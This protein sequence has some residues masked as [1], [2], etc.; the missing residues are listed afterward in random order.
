MLVVWQSALSRIHDWKAGMDEEQCQEEGALPVS[1][2]VDAVMQQVA[3]IARRPLKVHLEVHAIEA[4]IGVDE[5]IEHLHLGFSNYTKKTAAAKPKKVPSKGAAGAKAALDASKKKPLDVQ[6]REMEWWQQ[7]AKNALKLLKQNLNQLSVNISGLFQGRRQGCDPT[8]LVAA[9]EVGYQGPVNIQ[10]ALTSMSMGAWPF[11]TQITSMPDG[12]LEVKILLPTRTDTEGGALA[13]V[14]IEQLSVTISLDLERVQRLTQLQSQRVFELEL[15]PN[16]SA[17]PQVPSVEDANGIAPQKATEPTSKKEPGMGSDLHERLTLYYEQH[18]RDMLVQID[19]VLQL[20][21][22]REEELW[23]DMDHKYGTI[24]AQGGWSMLPADHVQM[25]A[26]SSL[27]KVSV[28]S[29]G[30]ADAPGGSSNAAAVAS[31]SDTDSSHS[32]KLSSGDFTTFSVTSSKIR[33]EVNYATCSNNS[34]EL[35][36]FLLLKMDPHRAFDFNSF[37]QLVAR[38]SMYLE[39][40]S[41]LFRFSLSVACLVEA[42]ELRFYANSLQQ[43]HE[44]AVTFHHVVSLWDFVDDLVELKTVLGQQIDTTKEMPE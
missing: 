14:S 11:P 16:L 25:G 12:L 20:Y 5:L 42:D 36:G 43:S 22:G 23:R 44:P 27:A 6:L 17:K 29:S 34:K 26:G 21:D 13:Q 40:E 18:N 37:R 30:D 4:G 24:M 7:E 28:G 8:L 15:A 31:A 32:L 35:L 10:L 2:S 39:S 9:T 3:L 33:C 38:F 41:F 1:I 19:Y